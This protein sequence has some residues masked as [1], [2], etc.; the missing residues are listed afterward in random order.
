VADVADWSQVDAA[1]T[2]P[3]ADVPPVHLFVPHMDDAL[4][5][6]CRDHL[7]SQEDPHGHRGE[8][9]LGQLWGGI[10]WRRRMHF[11]LFG[12]PRPDAQAPRTVA[13][14]VAETIAQAV[15]PITVLGQDREAAS[16]RMQLIRELAHDHSLEH[17]AWRTAQLARPAHYHPYLGWTREGEAGHGMGNGYLNGNGDNGGRGQDMRRFLESLWNRAKPTANYDVADRLVV[18]GVEVDFA[19][20]S[21]GGE[22]D[23][24]EAVLGEYRLARLVTGDPFT[25]TCVRTVHGLGL[26]DLESVHHYRSELARLSGAERGLILLVDG[27]FYTEGIKQSIRFS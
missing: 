4:W 17:L 25:V 6:R 15:A 13:G 8:E 21:G 27:A 5:A 18:T 7:R 24:N 26:D 1:P 19:A 16:S 2:I 3:P 22:S 14:L 11:L 10:T 23:L 9:R 12:G 20:V